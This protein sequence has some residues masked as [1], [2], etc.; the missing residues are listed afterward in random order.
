MYTNDT[1]AYEPLA[2]TSKAQAP[3]PQTPL[4]VEPEKNQADVA[5]K[6]INNS[7]TGT[8]T[9]NLSPET[10]KTIIQTL[11]ETDN[12]EAGTADARIR[13]FPPQNAPDGVKAAFAK[14]TERLSNSEM[15]VVMGQFIPS[16]DPNVKPYESPDFSYTNHIEEQLVSLEHFKGQISYEQYK[17]TK[18]FFTNF[19]S[20]LKIRNVA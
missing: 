12:D 19:L 9:S 7:V 5:E 10:T 14:A 4:A 1:T 17:T 15:L 6:P 20:E 3:L 11:Q 16:M 13:T 2:Q 18:E 8:T